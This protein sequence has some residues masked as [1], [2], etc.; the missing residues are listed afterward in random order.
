MRILG[1]AIFAHLNDGTEVFV[2]TRSLAKQI[3]INQGLESKKITNRIKD[4]AIEILLIQP[5]FLQNKEIPL[6]IRETMKAVAELELH[7]NQKDEKVYEKKLQRARLSNLLSEA[8]LDLVWSNKEKF[9]STNPTEIA[10]SVKTLYNYING[11]TDIDG[12]VQ[13]LAVSIDH[14]EYIEKLCSII[15]KDSPIKLSLQTTELEKNISPI[16]SEQ[17]KMIIP[18]EDYLKDSEANSRFLKLPEEHQKYIKNSAQENYAGISSTK[19][20]ELITL[21][22]QLETTLEAE[23]QSEFKKCMK[24]ANTQNAA[25]NGFIHFR[26][27]E[28][29][30]TMPFER[31][32]IQMNKAY[33]ESLV[34]LLISELY[35]KGKYPGVLD[36]KVAGPQVAGRTD[37]IVIYIGEASQKGVNETLMRQKAIKER[38]NILKKLKEIQQQRPELFGIGVMPFKQI[39]TPGI[40]IIPGLS[41]SESFTKNL[42]KAV[43]YALANSTDRKDFHNKIIESFFVSDGME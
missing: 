24:F 16:K 21:E 37:G 13:D 3:L 15:N 35:K 22:H 6:N 20:E 17:S 29:T 33:A 40:A 7:R 34:R 2:N 1:Y 25:R 32:Y 36:I 4:K 8:E 11:V 5:S 9:S 42:S 18:L 28:A 23:Q 43:V 19:K 31:I 14:F 26:L 12:N 27:Q 30:K 38:D 41:T 10:I 39:Y